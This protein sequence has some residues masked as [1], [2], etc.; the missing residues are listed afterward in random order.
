ML[1]VKSVTSSATSL[2]FIIPRRGNLQN[3]VQQRKLSKDLEEVKEKSELQEEE[4][5]NKKMV[6]FPN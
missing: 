2:K 1:T 6:S 5:Q 3:N 4:A